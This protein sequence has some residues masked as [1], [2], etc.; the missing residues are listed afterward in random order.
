MSG[1]FHGEFEAFDGGCVAAFKHRSSPFGVRFL[2]G[3][4]KARR[5][6]EGLNDDEDDISS[7][8]SAKR[9]YSGTNPKHEGL[10]SMEK[11]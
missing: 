5:N 11:R 4:K 10:Q 9:G 2:M 6:A 3:Q 7:T 8:R 1:E